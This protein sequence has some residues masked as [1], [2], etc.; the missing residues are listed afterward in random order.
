MHRLRLT[1]GVLTLILLLNSLSTTVV[2][3]TAKTYYVATNGS[4]TNPGTE[5]QPFLTLNK[6]VSVL[7]PGDTLLV[8]QGTYREELWNTIPSGL[9]WNQPVTL[10]AYPGHQVIIQP[11][12][13][14]DFVITIRGNRHYIIIDGFIIDGTNVNLEGIKINGV[15]TAA[16]SPSHIRLINNEIRNVG[17][18]KVSNGVYEAY[19]SGIFT[20]GR[21]NYVE[22]INNRIHNNGLTDFDHGIYHIAS[23]ALIEGNTIYNNKGTGIKV[24]WGQNALNNIVRNNV[25]YDNN[26]AEGFNGQKKQGRGIGVYAGSGTQVYNNV[27]WGAHMAGI[28]VSYAGHNAKI[29]NNTILQATGYGIVVGYDSSTITTSINTLVENNLVYQQSDSPAIYNDGG[30]GTIFRYNL[31]F[32][33]N[34]AIG[35]RYPGATVILNNLQNVDPR[36]INLGAKNFD[37]GSGSPAIDAGNNLNCP[38]TDPHGRFRTFDGNGDGKAQCDVGAYEYDQFDSPSAAGVAP[39]RNDFRT[40]SPTL[41]WS[42]IDWATRYQV[43]IDNNADFLSVNYVFNS[44]DNGLSLQVGPL[45]AGIFYWRVRGQHAD[46]SWG[47]W[48][49]SASILVRV[50]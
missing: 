12:P 48:S 30:R 45:A 22:Y 6:G 32:G 31:T 9:S 33:V 7:L 43:E 10:R 25:I 38:E 18:T 39:A 44:P 21:A 47:N 27:I 8:K 41:T 1:I 29:F 5:A 37:L 24:G 14:A 46:G 26:T 13:G 20:T 42:I 35:A 36:F 3:Q 16:P 11:D 2:A 50:S 17:T 40:D 23:Y 34:P 28:D 19:G 15:M 49:P 4:D